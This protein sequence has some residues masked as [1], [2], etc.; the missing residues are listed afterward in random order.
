MF[1]DIF[2]LKNNKLSSNLILVQT[3]F[4]FEAFRWW[5]WVNKLINSLMDK[6]SF[7][8][9]ER[10]IFSFISIQSSIND[11]AESIIFPKVLSRYQPHIITQMPV[12][13]L[14]VNHTVT[15]VRCS[16]NSQTVQVHSFFRVEIFRPMVL[17]SWFYQLIDRRFRKNS[18]SCLGDSFVG[19]H[20]QI[21]VQMADWGS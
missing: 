8:F 14:V 1:D 4:F 15:Q 17:V 21:V 13:H 18:F 7:N 12:N 16:V 10:S 20:V 9:I 6:N 2:P 3:F 19:Y 5:N 11:I